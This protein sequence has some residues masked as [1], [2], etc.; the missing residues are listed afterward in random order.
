MKQITNIAIKAWRLWK[1]WKVGMLKSPLNELLTYCNY[2]C[3]GHYSY[4]KQ[5]K[6]EYLYNN[7]LRILKQYL[8]KH[9][10]DNLI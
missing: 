7:H 2:M 3:N 8:P 4:L 10:V 6:N 9:H 1:L 5:F